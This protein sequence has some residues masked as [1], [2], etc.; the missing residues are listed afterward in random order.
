MKITVPPKLLAPI[1][2]IALA[3]VLAVG[4]LIALITSGS[5]SKSAPSPAANASTNSSASATNTGKGYLGLT[6]TQTPQQGLRVASVEQNG[7][8]AAAGIQAGDLI[9]AVDGKVVRTPEQLR[10]AVE[11]KAPGSQ[12]TIA[13][14]RGD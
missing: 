8:A 1:L 5:G 2:V 10:S 3:T 13:Y 6:V 12:S 14:E 9:R 7:P 11:A 4:A